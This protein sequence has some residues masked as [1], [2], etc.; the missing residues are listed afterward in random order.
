MLYLCPNFNFF[1]M[2]T[3]LS[4]IFTIFITTEDKEQASENFEFLLAYFSAQ[5]KDTSYFE[6]LKNTFFDY[7]PKEIIG[8]HSAL[9]VEFENLSGLK[10]H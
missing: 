2:N 10:I 4:D 6:K 1:S 8:I 5:N 9:K 7:E 3:D